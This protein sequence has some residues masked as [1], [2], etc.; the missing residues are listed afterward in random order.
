MRTTWI[1]LAV[2]A[3]VCAG[4]GSA[5]AAGVASPR[6]PGRAGGAVYG[7]VMEVDGSTVTVQTGNGLDGHFDLTP[8][9]RVTRILATIPSALTPGSCAVAGGQRNGQGSVSAVWVLVGGAA[10]CGPDGISLAT[11]PP[12][13]VVVGGTI[14]GVSGRDVTLR[15]SAG[16]DHVAIGIGTAMG[17]VGDA[18]AGDLMEGVCTVG[19]GR[20]G[21]NRELVAR[22]VTIVPAPTGGC[23]AGSSGV[24]SLAF[25]DP[26]SGTSP[27]PAAPP[28]PFI[29]GGA[30][31]V[32]TSG[33]SDVVG[34]GSVQPAVPSPA[35]VVEGS[36]LV[37]PPGPAGTRPAVGAAS[38]APA[39]AFVPPQQPQTVPAA[40]TPSS[41]RQPAPAPAT[42]PVPVPV[43]S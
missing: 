13:P 3:V 30:T 1:G 34:G 6:N 29:G 27:A 43:P 41:A 14:S 16:E 22:R 37:E 2:T 31:Q 15:T 40:P 9:T 5:A 38:A 17:A 10:G 7:E 32:L 8:R 35:A 18:T 24:G 20:R 23:F 4:C 19:R 11:A 33:Q 12:D 39:P 26:G 21:Q 42:T 25:L 36:G 28:P